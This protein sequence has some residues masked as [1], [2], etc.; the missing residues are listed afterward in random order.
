MTEAEYIDALAKEEAARAMLAALKLAE[1]LYQNGILATPNE[2]I[3][4]VHSA[5]RAAIAQAEA[6][7]IKG[8]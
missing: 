8:E 7:G 3:G 2:D 1:T 6:A 5:R 4:R